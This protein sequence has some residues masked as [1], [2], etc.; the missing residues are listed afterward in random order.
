M[1]NQKYDIVLLDADETVFDF[2]KS[3][4]YS[5]EKTLAEFGVEFNEERLKLYSDINLY[6][7]KALERGEVT[8]E[9]LKTKRFDMFFE[10]VGVANIDTKLFNERYV[11]YLSTC[12]FLLD[13]AYEFVEKLSKYCKLY[14]A[15]NGLTIVQRGRLEKSSI[16][17][18]LNGFF[19]SEEI[20]FAKPDKAYFEYILTDIKA[21]DKSRVII[22]GD[23][24]TSDMQG[25]KNIGIKTCLYNP[26]NN[27][28][29]KALCDYSV[30]NYDEFFDI[31]F[32]K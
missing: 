30:G 9:S 29:N 8:R 3:E 23:S 19:I 2:K 14:L 22:L 10:Q 17:P 28:Y 6:M 26:K 12:T 25:G 32:G 20:G 21:E 18:F 31:L 1:N 11:Y 7:W 27:E 13:G 4:A 24:E 16:K 15:T 5:F